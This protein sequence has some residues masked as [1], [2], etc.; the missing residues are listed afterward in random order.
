MKKWL[1]IWIA[2]AIAGCT[3]DDGLELPDTIDPD[4]DADVVVQDFMWKSMNLWYFWQAD[5]PDLADDAYTTT[6]EYTDFLASESDPGAF[7]DNRLRFSEDRFSFYNEDYTELTQGLAGISRSNGMAYG[8]IQYTGDPNLFGYVRYILPD[9]D[10]STKDIAR[11]DLFTGVNGVRLTA[12]NYRE[13]LLGED[14]TYTLNMAD[15][16]GNDVVPNGREVTLTKEENLQ[17]DPIFL[18][19]VFENVG[20]ETVGYM[21][22]NRFVNEF[23]RELN[24][25]FG[26][27]AA[28]GVTA[29]VLDLRYN[30]GGSANTARLL[31]SMIYGTKT[32]EVFSEE[33]WN[34]YIQEALTDGDP[35]ALKEFFASAVS[36]GVTLNTLNLDRVYLLTT[37]STASASELVINGLNPYMDVIKIGTR[38]RGKNEFS[39]TLVDDRDRTGAP[40]IYSPEREGDINSENTWAIQALVGRMKNADGVFG[41]PNGFTPDIEVQEDLGNLGVLGDPNEPLLAR[42]LQ[43]ISGV[44]AKRYIQPAMAAEPFTSSNV[45]LPLKDNMFLDKEIKIPE[46]FLKNFQ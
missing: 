18:T 36:S 29:L 28:S 11:G 24:D 12:E 22:Y 23:D 7:F 17:E 2:F 31:A 35:D 21:M 19:D 6:E 10:A 43:E 38:T 34:D 41:D 25:A 39:L 4:P 32:D 42:A 37:R 46:R 20:G 5:V 8:L 13:L 26:F 30:P 16:Q 27:F 33:Q 1:F 45:L 40:Y 3:N 15:L 44:A 14:P 9:S